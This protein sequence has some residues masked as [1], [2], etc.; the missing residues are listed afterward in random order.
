MKAIK[1]VCGILPQINE[2]P[3]KIFFW[4]NETSIYTTT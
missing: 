4:I 3:F 2:T 1:A